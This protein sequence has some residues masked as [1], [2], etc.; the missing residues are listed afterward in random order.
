MEAITIPTLA[1][2]QKDAKGA[3]ECIETI[4]EM[5]RGG[6]IRQKEEYSLNTKAVE[7]LRKLCEEY[8]CVAFYADWCGDSRRALPV[9]ALI[10]EQTGK[11]IIARGGMTKP[12]YGSKQLWAVPPSPPEVEI[13]KITSSPTILIFNNEGLEIGRI[14]TRQRM[15]TTLEEEIVKIIED[16]M[17]TRKKK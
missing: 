9:L 13:F 1:D 5:Y 4:P 16:D 7:R 2:I 14:K 3:S 15:T 6:F 11:K 17:K 8:T 12:P 10:E